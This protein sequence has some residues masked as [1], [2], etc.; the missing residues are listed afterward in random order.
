MLSRDSFCAPEVEIFKAVKLWADFNNELNNNTSNTIIGV[1]TSHSSGGRGTKAPRQNDTVNACGESDNDENINNN[2]DGSNNK[3]NS[4]NK[5]NVND[6]DE[7]AER[8]NII[9]SNDEGSNDTT[10]NDNPLNEEENNGEKPASENHLIKHGGENFNDDYEDEFKCSRD[11]DD[12]EIITRIKKL[13][14]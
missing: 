5:N 7:I 13:V 3:N 2:N 1:V 8:N 6:S 14:R 10:N 9:T 11:D 12:D 4:K